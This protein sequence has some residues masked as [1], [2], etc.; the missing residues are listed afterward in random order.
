VAA[1]SLAARIVGLDIAG[2]DL[3]ARTS[4]ARW[5]AGRRHRRGQCRPRPADAP[6]ARRRQAAPGGRGH[7]RHLFARKK[8]PHPI[9]GV[10]GTHGKTT[11][12]RLVARICTC[13][14][15]TRAWPAATACS[16]ANASI[17][18]GKRANWDAATA[19]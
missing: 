15:S 19:C 10:T 2:V 17:E 18:R 9:V 7:R 4:R 12:A 3:V 11:I 1:A 6:Q 16:S 5:P 14:A 13:R 8:R